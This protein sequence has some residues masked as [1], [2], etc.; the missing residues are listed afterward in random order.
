MNKK[1]RDRLKSSIVSLD[2]SIFTGVVADTLKADQT[3]SDKLKQ[4]ASILLGNADGLLTDIISFHHQCF[5]TLYTDCKKGPDP[6]VRFQFQWHNHCSALLLSREYSL[7]DIDLVELP[8]A[9]VSV[10]RSNWLSFCE[11]NRVPVPKSN[12]LMFLVSSAIYE[13]LLDYSKN[14]QNTLQERDVC[15][16]SVLTEPDTADVYYRFGGAAICDMLHLHYKQLRTCSDDQRDMLSQET[17]LLQAMN[18]K[19]KTNVPGYLRYRDHGFMYFPE[20]EFFPLMREV[21]TVVKT[22]VNFNGLKQEGD[23]LIKVIF[24]T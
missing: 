17:S 22:V 8:S 23:N 20:K 6:F 24:C 12:P 14:F 21:D 1:E 3:L 5:A 4:L 9:P 10:V 11:T 2:P 15:S 16:N 13:F 7:S 19:D 18:C